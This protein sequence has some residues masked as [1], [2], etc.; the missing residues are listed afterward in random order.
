MNHV[1]FAL[2]GGLPEDV[3]GMTP[4]ITITHGPG[5]GSSNSLMEMEQ[6][7]LDFVVVTDSPFESD[8]QVRVM[9]Y[10]LIALMES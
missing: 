3:T 5:K 6:S 8:F 9:E 10:S 7:V 2:S 1:K 4:S